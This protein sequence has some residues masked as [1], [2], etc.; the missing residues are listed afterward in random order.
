MEWY[1]FSRFASRGIEMAF[2]QNQVKE[3]LFRAKSESVADEI[4]A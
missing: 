2:W 1:R 3:S 4:M